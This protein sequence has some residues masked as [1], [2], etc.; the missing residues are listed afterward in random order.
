M[1]CRRTAAAHGNTPVSSLGILFNTGAGQHILK[2]PL[3]VNS[4]IDKVGAAAGPGSRAVP[5]PAAEPRPAAPCR[6]LSARCLCVGSSLNVAARR[7]FT[8]DQRCS[9]NQ[10]HGI[11]VLPVSH[12]LL[13]KRLSRSLDIQFQLF[14]V[15]KALTLILKSNDCTKLVLR[16]HS[17]CYLSLGCPAPHRCHSGSGPG[18]WKPDSKD[19]GEGQKSKYKF[20]FIHPSSDWALA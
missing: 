10:C 18:N 16:K 1:G 6:L 4:I 15:S 3:V 8:R 13:S 12:S 11:L 5:G 7:L 14:T 9:I 17:K 19:A 20:S 2:N